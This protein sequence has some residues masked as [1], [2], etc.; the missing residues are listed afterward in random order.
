MALTATQLSEGISYWRTTGWPQDFHNEFYHRLQNGNPR[1][2]FNLHWWQSFVSELSKWKALRPRSKEFVSK[3]A[4]DRFEK[5][6]QVWAEVMTEAVL[7]SDISA[8]KWSQVS[9]FADL[10]AEIKD[11]TSPVFTSKFCHFLAPQIFPVIDNAAMGS[12]FRTYEHYYTAAQLEWTETPEETQLQLVSE[13]PRQM[14]D[15]AIEG[16]P[17][18]CKIIELCLIGR[19]RLQSP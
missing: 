8:V 2:I 3:R 1:G 15:P 19:H 6:T 17:F 14:A 9:L 4:A 16:Y 5:L 18:K 10:V 11:V 7:G 12:P 13:L